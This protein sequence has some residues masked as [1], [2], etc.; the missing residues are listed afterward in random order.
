MN[1]VYCHNRLLKPNESENVQDYI[2]K[3]IY[4]YNIVMLSTKNN[5][6]NNSSLCAH[7]G[8]FDNLSIN[9]FIIKTSL[10]SSFNNISWNLSTNS[11]TLNNLTN[12]LTVASNT[13]NLAGNLKFDNLPILKV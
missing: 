9:R 3:Y 6:N 12:N 11:G 4:I 1:N 7:S 8:T 5:N 10:T 13:V 2:N